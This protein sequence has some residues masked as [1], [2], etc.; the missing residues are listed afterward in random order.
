[1]CARRRVPVSLGAAAVLIALLA[2]RSCPAAASGEIELARAD[3]LCRVGRAGE[4]VALMDETASR[5]RAAGDARLERIAILKRGL[6]ELYFRRRNAEALRDGERAETLAMAARDSAHLCVALRVQGVALLEL[7]RLGEASARMRRL[8]AVAARIGARDEEGQAHSNLGYVE[9]E[10]GHDRAALACYRRALERLE[11][12]RNRFAWLNA[13]IGLARAHQDRSHPDSARAIY[14]EVI[15]EAH[16]LGLVTIEAYALN[17]LGIYEWTSGDPAWAARCWERSIELHRLQSAPYEM[18]A[19]GRQRAMAMLS[20]GRV[21]EG[22]RALETMVDSLW[23]V[24]PPKWRAWI[25]ADLARVRRWQG[26]PR[27]AITLFGRFFSLADSLPFD[28]WQASLAGLAGAH[29]DLGDPAGALAAIHA[30]RA[31]W[32]HHPEDPGPLGLA[33][34]VEA[35]LRLGRA[36]EAA[37]LLPAARRGMG[38]H[39]GS[40]EALGLALLEIRTRRALGDRAAALA[41]ARRATALWERHRASSRD[42]EW[43]EARGRTRELAF[44]LARLALEDPGG[45]PDSR[46]RAAFDAVQPFRARTLAERIGGGD[47]V[48]Q[49]RPVRADSLQR[50]VLEPGEVYVEYLAGHDST[51]RFTVTRGAIR[52][53]WLPPPRELGARNRRLLDLVLPGEGRA[54]ASDPATVEAAARGFGVTLLG[55]SDEVFAGATRVLFS[56][57]G[58]LC[59]VPF[60]LLGA[61]GRQGPLL[62]SAEVAV[63]PSAAVLAHARLRARVSGR[64]SGRVLALAGPAESGGRRLKGAAREVA[65]LES[66]FA[67]VTVPGA[68]ELASG[69]QLA[70]AMAQADVVHIAAHTEVDDGAPWRSGVRLAP[71]PREAVLR[72]RDVARLRLGARLT[73][74]AGCRTLGSRVGFGEGP[75]GLASGFLAAGVPTTVAT[76]WEVDDAGAA[77]FAQAFY[78]RLARGLS[79]AAALRETQLELRRDPGGRHPFVWAAFTLVG[80]PGTRVALAARGAAVEARRSAPGGRGGRVTAPPPGR[81]SR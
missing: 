76:L 6:T 81:L 32:G 24:A 51:L 47:P 11:G 8:E 67:G 9:L 45:T 59:G 37:A 72:A 42:P 30:G 49:P 2:P 5:A 68:A 15:E 78:P 48:A 7:E 65:W 60:G 31:R 16:A 36:R 34:E 44:L 74:L 39:P 73:V 43:R 61:P 35:L 56:P 53:A 26:R 41:A 18:L 66:E 23:A 1:M 71:P 64:P 33:S 22:A 63:V 62:G 12:T 55:G 10:R 77:R 80:E 75:Q 13:R 4:A 14:R 58:P 17:N 20:L 52:V 46:A 29:F 3:S 69:D 57:D 79:A 70:R 28:Q 40:A 27:D 25:L 38:P 50:R 54:A 19:P 21:D